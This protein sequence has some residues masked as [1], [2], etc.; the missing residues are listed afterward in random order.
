MVNH[1]LSTALKTFRYAFLD[2]IRLWAFDNAKNHNSYAYDTPNASKM[3]LGPG[4]DR[5]PKI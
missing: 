1:T 4:G 3:N 2:C 5:Q